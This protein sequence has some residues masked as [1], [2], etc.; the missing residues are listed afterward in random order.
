MPSTEASEGDTDSVDGLLTISAIQK[1]GQKLKT[2]TN[3]AWKRTFFWWSRAWV[4]W[5]AGLK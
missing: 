5:E 2:Q 4:Q 1:G 3:A